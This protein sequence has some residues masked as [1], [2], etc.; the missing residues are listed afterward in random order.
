MQVE[1]LW[2]DD[3][4]YPGWTDKNILMGI[5]EVEIDTNF[6]TVVFGHPLLD[7][8][9]RLYHP[10]R[11]YATPYNGLPIQPFY[12]VSK[13]TVWGCIRILVEHY[14]HTHPAPCPVSK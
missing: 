14:K 1:C 11:R 12:F 7:L 3:R 4:A 8:L 6:V 10:P 2:F 9:N 5:R 13:I